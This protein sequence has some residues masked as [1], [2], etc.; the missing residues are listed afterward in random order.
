MFEIP[1]PAA[2]G[3]VPPVTPVPTPAPAPVPPA[4]SPDPGNAAFAE[5]RTKLAAAEREKQ[6]LAD[7]LTALERKDM[8]D[9]TRIEAER[10]DALKKVQ[11]L[12]PLRDAHGKFV[13]Q[14]ETACANELA[15]IPEDKRA[16]IEA[17]VS[18][19]PL[20]GRL[21]AIQSMRSA[22]GA[23]PVSSGTVTQ[24]GGNPGAGLPGG[25]DAPK[26]IEAKDLGKLSWADALKG[27]QSAGP[28]TNIESLV[29]AEVQKHVAALT[30]KK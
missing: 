20:E 8:D 23:P 13:S 24:P 4:G 19:I 26:P 2:P 28:S 27:H 10:N 17:V 15:Q 9:K 16:A 22:I 1:T 14:L 6:E 30:A 29:A 18:Q 5:M 21:T 7:R 3:V 12:E 25:P 11:E